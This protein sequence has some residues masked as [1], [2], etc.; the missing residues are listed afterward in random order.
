MKTVRSLVDSAIDCD[1][2]MDMSWQKKLTSA[3][4]ALD[5]EIARLRELEDVKSTDKYILAA[6]VTARAEGRNEGL[7]EAAVM[8]DQKACGA[9]RSYGEFGNAIR[10]L[11]TKTDGGAA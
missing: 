2:P 5:A 6:F 4:D 7:D 10:A 1:G 11:K 3:A 8:A 9:C